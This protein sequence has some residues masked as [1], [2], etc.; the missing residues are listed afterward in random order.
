MK[1]QQLI[2]IQK[3]ASQNKLS[4]FQVI[5]KIN[6]GELKTI[7]Q[8][9]KELI[10]LD[11]KE[12]KPKIQKSSALRRGEFHVE[13]KVAFR[14]LLD[15]C[16]Y[17]VL[18]LIDGESPYSVPLNFAYLENSIIFHGAMEGKKISLIK[19]NPNASFSVV[20]SYSFL[21]S[22]FSNTTSACPATQFFA[23]IFVSG[24]IS[25]VSDVKLKSKALNALMQKMQPENGYEKIEPTNPI[26]EKMLDKTAVFALHVESST[27][28]IKA[29]QNLSAEKKEN[30]IAHLLKRDSEVDKQTI[31]LIKKYS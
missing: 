19:T 11:T 30:L 20:K 4:T 23:S 21:P 5:K 14:E 1:N 8:D 26:Y 12:A 6:S 18:S 17:G 29:G 15:S 24:Q 22:Y 10:V 16:E 13:D 27:L 3:Y 2:T 25:I 9:G 7:K 31:E 28:K